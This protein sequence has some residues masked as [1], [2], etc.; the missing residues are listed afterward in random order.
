MKEYKTYIIYIVI[1]V[2]LYFLYQRY[3][4]AKNL[5]DKNYLEQGQQTG[6]IKTPLG[7]DSFGDPVSY[8]Q[9]PTR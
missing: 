4:V 2:I 9:V 5:T 8:A 7:I 1:A 3:M 6:G